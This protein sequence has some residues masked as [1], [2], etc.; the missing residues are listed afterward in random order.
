MR[1]VWGRGGIGR[2]SGLKIRRRKACGFESHRPYQPTGA[3]REKSAHPPITNAC[4]E[5]SLHVPRSHGPPRRQALL[6]KPGAMLRAYA[7]HGG[8]RSHSTRTRRVRRRAW[9]LQLPP[10]GSA[11]RAELH[12]HRHA[13]RRQCLLALLRKGTR[14]QVPLSR[15]SRCGDA[16]RRF[17]ALGRMGTSRIR[18]RGPPAA[19]RGPGNLC[20]PGAFLLDHHLL[21]ASSQNCVDAGHRRAFR[22]VPR[23]RLLPVFHRNAARRS[24]VLP[25]IRRVPRHDRTVR[26]PKNGRFPS[27]TGARQQ[28]GRSA[29][30]ARLGRKPRHARQ[31]GRQT[32][33]C[34]G[35]VHHGS[36]FR[37][38]RFAHGAG[39]PKRPIGHLHLRRR[40]LP[41]RDPL[42]GRFVRDEA[43]GRRSS[44]SIRLPSPS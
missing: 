12:V 37:P 31:G 39:W 38:D 8:E 23:L 42:A 1:E 3:K 34:H 14:H 2:R 21:P 35:S 18:A 43:G 6:F 25:R 33:L 36:Q 20:Q 13:V 24:P 29:A 40:H 5:R 27:G 26:L 17:R 22:V 16:F 15:S 44:S 11:Y 32:Q 19:F 9:H 41:R 7:S 4:R 30:S 10:S 28:Y